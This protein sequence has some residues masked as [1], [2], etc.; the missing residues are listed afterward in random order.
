MRERRRAPDAVFLRGDI[1]KSQR[2]SERIFRIFQRFTMTQLVASAA[3]FREV[4]QGLVG[5][6]LDHYRQD[7]DFM[8]LSLEF[9]L[10]ATRD[11]GVGRILSSY[12][13]GLRDQIAGLLRTGRNEGVVRDDLDPEMLAILVFALV[14]GAALQWGVDPERIDPGRLRGS[15]GDAVAILLAELFLQPVAVRGLTL[16]TENLSGL[17]PSR[18]RRVRGRCDPGSGPV[19]RQYSSRPRARG[20]ILVRTAICLRSEGFVTSVIV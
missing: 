8:R 12:Y 5:V 18:R 2:E 19:V 17:G 1:A 14:D 16:S 11:P 4:L 13:A 10:E 7:P 6:W 20:C 15:L 9:R 3:S